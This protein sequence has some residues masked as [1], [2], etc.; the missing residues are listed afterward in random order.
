MT[1]E[2]GIKTR[3]RARWL[4]HRLE[5]KVP[6]EILAAMTDEELIE[7]Y[8]AEQRGKLDRLRAKHASAEKT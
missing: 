6:S 7:Q 5:G 2:S 8:E 3:T 1:A 4:R